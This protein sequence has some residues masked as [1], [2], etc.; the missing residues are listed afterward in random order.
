MQIILVF[1]QTFNEKIINS[2][3]SLYIKT[4]AS[5]QRDRSWVNDSSMTLEG[6]TAA[7]PT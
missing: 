3:S 2:F 5:E 1:N 7:A 6:C 4:Q